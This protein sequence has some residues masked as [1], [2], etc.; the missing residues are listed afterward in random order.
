[1]TV[2]CEINV[3]LFSESAL[4]IVT[5]VDSVYE[6]L[7]TGLGINAANRINYVEF[8]CIETAAASNLHLISWTSVALK[9]NDRIAIND[10]M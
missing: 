3:V 7:I 5:S 1:M 4:S 6:R 2:M 8:R 10:C 9:I